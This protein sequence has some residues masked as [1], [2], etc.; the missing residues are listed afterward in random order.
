MVVLVSKGKESKNAKEE[1]KMQ[2]RK[3]SKKRII[4]FIFQQFR[5]IDWC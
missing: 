1:A 4:F 2:K 5:Q 3:W